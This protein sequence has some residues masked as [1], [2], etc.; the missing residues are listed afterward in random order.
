MRGR[1]LRPAVELPRTACLNP[2]PS[3]YKQFN[4]YTLGLLAAEISIG[5]LWLLGSY[6][7]APFFLRSTPAN[8]RSN[9][10]ALFNST[11]LSRLLLMLYLVYPG[12]SVAIFGA[13]SI[14]RARAGWV[15]SC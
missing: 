4:G 7:L 14:R 3:Y 5:L 6:I 12:V 13:H 11:V 15:S 8:E 2:S 1:L 10:L 9:R